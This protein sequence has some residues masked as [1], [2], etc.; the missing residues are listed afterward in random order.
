MLASGRESPRSVSLTLISLRCLSAEQGFPVTL[1]RVVDQPIARR[2][3]STG[4]QVT[5]HERI[6]EGDGGG[7]VPFADRRDLADKESDV[8]AT[9]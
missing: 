5:S 7:V 2:D 4:H 6:I 9:R 3:G 1:C 8:H